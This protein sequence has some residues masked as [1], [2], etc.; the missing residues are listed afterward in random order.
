MGW[1]ERRSGC[2]CP[3]MRA[4]RRENNEFGEFQKEEFGGRQRVSEFNDVTRRVNHCQ[5]LLIVTAGLPVTCQTGKHNADSGSED[6]MRDGGQSEPVAAYHLVH[7]KPSPQS[8][9]VQPPSYHTASRQAVSG[10]IQRQRRRAEQRSAEGHTKVS[11]AIG[12]IEED[13]AVGHHIGPHSR[14]GS[15]WR[16]GCSR[17]TGHPLHTAPATGTA[18][19][20]NSTK[21]QTQHLHWAGTANRH[22]RTDSNE[23]ID[24]RPPIEKA[25]K[26]AA[27]GCALCTDSGRGPHSS[28]CCHSM[29][30]FFVFVAV[31]RCMGGA[32]IDV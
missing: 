17:R 22:N 6:R 10:T 13:S 8:I 9:P 23:T 4:Y 12:S 31:A 14:C 29:S 19:R 1:G 2:C 16:C 11:N 32:Y 15:R 28:K 26:A 5:F 27:P 24:R 7:V 20:H 18:N 25:R 30:L 21:G 3:R